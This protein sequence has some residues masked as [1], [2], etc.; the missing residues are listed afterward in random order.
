[1]LVV[2]GTTDRIVGRHIVGDAAAKS[3]R[4]LR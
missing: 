2:D 1:M 4:R 3:S